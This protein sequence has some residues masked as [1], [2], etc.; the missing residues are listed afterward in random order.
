MPALGDV[1][2]AVSSNVVAHLKVQGEWAGHGKARDAV[3][4]ILAAQPGSRCRHGRLFY[5][6][7]C[8]A[9]IVVR[10]LLGNDS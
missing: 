2:S 10:R 7:R 4:V 1:H 6:Q 8:S 9:K 3:S 5:D